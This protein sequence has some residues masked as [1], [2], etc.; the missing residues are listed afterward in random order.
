M[1]KSKQILDIL[2]NLRMVVPTSLKIN[3]FTEHIVRLK[4]LGYSTP[5]MPKGQSGLWV[6]VDI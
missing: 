5:K 6:V 4:V 2:V 1:E 3:P